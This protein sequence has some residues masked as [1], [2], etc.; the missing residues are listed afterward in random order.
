M[1]NLNPLPMFY[2]QKV[3]PAVFDDSLS[4]YE[5]LCKLRA[6]INEVIDVVG[7]AATITALKEAIALINDELDK[8]RAYVDAQDS[9]EAVRADKY[10]DAMNAELEQ[11]LLNVIYRVGTGDVLVNSQIDGRK[12]QHLQFELDGQYDYS[13][14]FAISC[15]EFDFLDTMASNWDSFQNNG[16]YNADVGMGLM[17]L[18]DSAFRSILS[19]YDGTV[20]VYIAMQTLSQVVFG[21]LG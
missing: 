20:N 14:P 1:I 17:V 8:L 13:R 5:Q 6:K 4:Y 2:C 11:S 15:G 19:E 18:T 21:I 16:A 12:K 7:D 3:L 10:S 9:A